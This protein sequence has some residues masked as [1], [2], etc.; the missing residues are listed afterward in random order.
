[1]VRHWAPKP[2]Y[3]ASLVVRDVDKMLEKSLFGLS[4]KPIYLFSLSIFLPETL[5]IIEGVL[6]VRFHVTLKKEATCCN[7][8]Q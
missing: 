4:G 2:F 7:F 6:E 3:P 5:D 1:M 8:R